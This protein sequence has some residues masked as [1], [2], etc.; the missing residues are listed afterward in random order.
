MYT[1]LALDIETGG[2]AEMP[3]ARKALCHW[4]GIAVW[5]PYVHCVVTQ[6]MKSLEDIIVPSQH[7][8]TCFYMLLC[9][10]E[11]VLQNRSE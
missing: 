9:R 8:A 10:S 3:I 4:R 6:D 2:G 5:A 7:G 11:F 1:L